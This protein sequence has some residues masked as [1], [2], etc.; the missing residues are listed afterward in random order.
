RKEVFRSNLNALMLFDGAQVDDLAIAV[1]EH[2]A[3][4]DRAK[5]R[6]LVLTD[7]MLGLSAQWA[8][9]VYG[10]WARQDALY[11][12]QFDSLLSVTDT[13][14]LRERV[15]TDDAGHWVQY[16]RAQEINDLLI[17]FLNERVTQEQGRGHQC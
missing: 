12:D 17:R 15:I 1:Q 4:R 3:P 9:P 8:C 14:G 2:S 5:G 16:E 6:T 13:L 11:R 10:I 7:I